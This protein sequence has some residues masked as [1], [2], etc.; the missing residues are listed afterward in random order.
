MLAQ[1]MPEANEG[2]LSRTSRCYD[3]DELLG[4]IIVV[5]IKSS[6]VVVSPGDEFVEA[7]DGNIIFEL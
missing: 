5:S 7:L 2:W 6:G 3:F 1:Y 4:N